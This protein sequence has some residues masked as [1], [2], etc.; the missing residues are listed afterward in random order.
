V[1][2][3]GPAAGSSL[4]MVTNLVVNG[5]DEKRPLIRLL[6]GTVG[7]RPFRLTEWSASLSGGPSASS[8][9]QENENQWS[10]NKPLYCTVFCSIASALEHG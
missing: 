3:G 6:E 5:L 10:K 8:G 1:P 9:H 2:A 4:L 7:K